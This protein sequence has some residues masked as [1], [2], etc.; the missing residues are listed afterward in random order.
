MGPAGQR[1]TTLHLYPAEVAIS[2]PRPLA[3]LWSYVGLMIIKNQPDFHHCGRRER[4]LKGSDQ[5][6]M[7]DTQRDW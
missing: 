1:G 7:I 5:I 4:N 6:A 3:S 2:S